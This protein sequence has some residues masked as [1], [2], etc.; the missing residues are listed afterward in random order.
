M[1]SER[2]REILSLAALNNEEIGKKLHSA[3]GQ[4]SGILRICSKKQAAETARNLF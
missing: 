2:E 1:L 4:Y 3:V